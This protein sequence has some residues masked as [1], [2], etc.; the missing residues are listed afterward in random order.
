MCGL[1]GLGGVRSLGGLGGLGSM[2]GVGGLGS[3]GSVRGLGGLGVVGS[4]GGVG[5]QGGVRGR[6]VGWMRVLPMT[7]ATVRRWGV[8]MHL[9][10]R[11]V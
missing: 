9:R 7:R 1:G 4:L 10:W 3:V 8:R 2:R 5:S 6:D 11:Q